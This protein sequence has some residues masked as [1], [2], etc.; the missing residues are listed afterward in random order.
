MTMNWT[1]DTP[2]TEGEYWHKHGPE[3]DPSIYKV[4]KKYNSLWAFSLEYEGWNHIG[5]LDG[6]WQ[7]PIKPV[8][9]T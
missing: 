1:L 4:R 2:T 6:F 7:G 9:Q 5:R 8:E 3:S